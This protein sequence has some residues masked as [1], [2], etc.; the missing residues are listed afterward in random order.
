VK[1]STKILKE[2]YGKTEI[3]PQFPAIVGRLLE[4]TVELAYAA[5]LDSKDIMGHVM[6]VIHNEAKKADTYPTLMDKNYNNEE[7]IVE[8]ADCQM[9]YQFIKYHWFSEQEEEQIDA[10]EVEKAKLFQKLYD[11]NRLYISQDGKI[12]RKV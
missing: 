1:E 3:E 6:D 5:G 4:E 2:I 9:W 12:Y 8:M 10:G 11:E 7:T